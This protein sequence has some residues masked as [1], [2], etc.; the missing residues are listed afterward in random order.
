MSFSKILLNNLEGLNK[1]MSSWD[2]T[3]VSE[4]S[5]KSEILPIAGASIKITLVSNGKIYFKLQTGTLSEIEKA[6][7]DALADYIFRFKTLPSLRELDHFL[8]DNAL[9]AAWPESFKTE[10]LSQAIM[11]IGTLQSTHFHSPVDWLKNKLGHDSLGKLSI[12]V[13]QENRII[14]NGPKE[15]AWSIEKN[16][17]EWQQQ[18]RQLYQSPQLVLLF[19]IKS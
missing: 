6:V 15:D 9:K 1:G 18:L 7:L 11:S 8:R 3:Y 16:F 19:A 5:D 2:A 12:Q 14:I 10:F 17:D 13:V 4:V